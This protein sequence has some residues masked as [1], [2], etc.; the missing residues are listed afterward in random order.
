MTLKWMGAVLVMIGCGGF[1]FTLA[2]SC[3]RETS[4]LFQLRNAL[5]Y[6]ENELTFR[7]TP[8]PQLCRTTAHTAKGKIHQIFINLAEELESQIYPDATIC[9]QRA[10]GKYPDLPKS[11]RKTCK[12]LGQSLGS[13]ELTGQIQGLEASEEMCRRELERIKENQVERLREYRTL[14][15]CAGAALTIILL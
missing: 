5:R 7:M 4:M 15:I 1:G 13:F 8:L 3:K 14:G 12:L 6:M 9:M 10:L 2:A 11:V